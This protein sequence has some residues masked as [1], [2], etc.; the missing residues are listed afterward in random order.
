MVR[1]EEWSKVLNLL[2]VVFELPEEHANPIAGEPPMSFGAFA[3]VPA[4]GDA[5][6]RITWSCPV[7]WCGGKP[8]FTTLCGGY[9]GPPYTADAEHDFLRADFTVRRGL[10]DAAARLCSSDGH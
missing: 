10:A 5:T 8:R 4:A 6:V 2:H 1:P 3:R 9:N 7:S